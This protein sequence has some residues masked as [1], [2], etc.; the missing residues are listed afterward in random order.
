MM[1]RPNHGFDRNA[2]HTEDRYVCDCGYKDCQDADDAW[3]D[4]AETEMER[5]RAALQQVMARLADLLESDQFNNIEA[6]VLNAGVDY[7]ELDA[8]EE[9]SDE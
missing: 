5:L 1:K 9:T 7:P 6:L 8:A 2:S 3:M 4:W